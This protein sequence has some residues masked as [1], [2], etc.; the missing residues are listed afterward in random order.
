MACFQPFLKASHGLG[1]VGQA[2]RISATVSSVL[3]LCSPL[4]VRLE[5]VFT[6][7]P[8]GHLSQLW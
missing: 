8:Y 7:T 4:G 5:S 1:D 2:H 3:G 6:F